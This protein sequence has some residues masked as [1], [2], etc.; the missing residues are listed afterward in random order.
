MQNVRRCSH[1]GCGS[2][3]HTIKTC[4]LAQAD[5]IKTHCPNAGDANEQY[6]RHVA[7]KCVACDQPGHT[8]GT[9]EVLLPT[10]KRQKENE[11]ATL[12]A[13]NQPVPTDDTERSVVADQLYHSQCIATWGARRRSVMCSNS[14][15]ISAKGSG[16]CAMGSSRWTW[17]VDRA[18]STSLGVGFS[19]A[20]GAS[21]RLQMRPGM[22][23]SVEQSGNA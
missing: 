6:Q 17:I 8:A 20:H 4:P 22:W 1:P 10:H 13:F 21:R 12:V 23:R 9:C 18:R 5:W 2:T 15:H 7:P 3:E 14:R 16:D 19:V 11:I